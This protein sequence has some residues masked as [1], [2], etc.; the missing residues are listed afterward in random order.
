[1][2]RTRSRPKTE[3]KFQNAVLE[4]IARDGCCAVGINAVAHEAG[5]DKVLIYRYF[6]GMDGLLQRVADSRL[7]LPAADDVLGT[8]R[9]KGL[10]APALLAKVC[11]AVEDYITA[12]PTLAKLVA[13]RKAEHNPLTNHFSVEWQ[14]LWHTLPQRISTGLNRTAKAEWQQACALAALV[15]ESEICGEPIDVDCMALIAADLSVGIIPSTLAE[16]IGNPEADS[17]RRR[18]DC[19]FPE[20]L[21]QGD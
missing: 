2:P 14:K 12:D 7:W 3:E 18:M 13:W 15:V 21:T 11:L 19:P 9:T 20:F 4:L 5:A 17:Y 10:N 6:G 16:V 1:M 8:F